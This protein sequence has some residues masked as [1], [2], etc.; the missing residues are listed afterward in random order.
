M[1]QPK[2]PTDPPPGESA[3]PDLDAF[4]VFDPEAGEEALRKRLNLQVDT[5]EAPE[6]EFP[7]LRGDATIT[8]EVSARWKALREAERQK[9]RPDPWPIVDVLCA[10]WQ[11]AALTGAIEL[12]VFTVNSE[13][14]PGS[15]GS[16]PA[17]KSA[18]EAPAASM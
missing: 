11:S 13:R 3:A 12:G 10:Y 18:N 2:K 1:S 8:R 14:S 17:R 16:R 6:T 5:T 4:A 7:P 15:C 9:D